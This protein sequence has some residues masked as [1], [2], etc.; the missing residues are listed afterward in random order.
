VGQLR[1]SV[2]PRN[3]GGVFTHCPLARIF[4]LVI[5]N[6]CKCFLK[7]QFVYDKSHARKLE[8]LWQAFFILMVKSHLVDVGTQG[9]SYVVSKKFQAFQI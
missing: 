6:T 2:S 1:G 9:S 8:R 3:G 5:V 4:V 7:E